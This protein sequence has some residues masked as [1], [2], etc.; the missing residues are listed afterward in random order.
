MAH[1]LQLRILGGHLS[2]DQD[3]SA[4]EILIEYPL[5]RVAGIENAFYPRLEI[6]GVIPV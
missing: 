2:I 5:E 3:S 4:P 1:Y 6:L